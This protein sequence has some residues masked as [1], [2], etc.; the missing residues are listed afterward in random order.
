MSEIQLEVESVTVKISRKD[1]LDIIN[2]MP[3]PIENKHEGGRKLYKLLQGCFL[4]SKRGVH[5]L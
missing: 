1:A 4:D 5:F 3:Q 2:S